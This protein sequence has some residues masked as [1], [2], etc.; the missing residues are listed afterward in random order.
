MNLLS[1]SSE[2]P[3]KEAQFL[4]REVRENPSHASLLASGAL[5]VIF[6]PWL[7]LHHLPLCMAFP[8]CVSMGKSLFPAGLGTHPSMNSTNYICNDPISK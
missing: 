5:L 1:H 4:L 2:V 6:D 3:Q 7:L 8:L